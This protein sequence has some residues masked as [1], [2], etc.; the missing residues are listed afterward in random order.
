MC[1][2]TTI[3]EVEQLVEPGALDPNEIHT[4][5]VY[6]QQVLELTP[7]QAAAKRIEKVTVRE[8]AV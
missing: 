6:V 1:G 3:A 2:R 7:E 5:G 4:P 8:V